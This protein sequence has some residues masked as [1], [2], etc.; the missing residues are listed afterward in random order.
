M[1][2]STHP[3][4]PEDCVAVQAETNTVDDP[5][6][7]TVDQVVCHSIST[8]WSQSANPSPGPDPV[9]FEAV[10]R[11]H[12]INGEVLLNNV[13]KDT[14][15]E[16]LGLKAL[17][18][19][20]TVLAIINYLRQ[21]SLKYQK[22]NKCDRG[23]SLHLSRLSFPSVHVLLPF[24]SS[25]KKQSLSPSSLQHAFSYSLP[26]IFP[27]NEAR[28]PSLSCLSFLHSCPGPFP[29]ITI[30]SSFSIL[31]PCLSPMGLSCRTFQ[32]RP[33]I[34]FYHSDS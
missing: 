5:F 18:P 27:G 29:F 7:W 33:R 17:G 34:F 4:A 16:D 6:D 28:L 13:D 1:E 23:K 11:E 30:I 14:L 2:A 3:I 15:R 8:L 25:F 9:T 20:S 22:I 31:L 21:N 32:T 26:I 10:L 12:V 19:R 24:L